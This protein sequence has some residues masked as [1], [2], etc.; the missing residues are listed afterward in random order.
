MKIM[1][2]A[3][4][5]AGPDKSSVEVPA[6]A[7]PI[8]IIIFARRSDVGIRRN[9]VLEKWVKEALDSARWEIRSALSSLG[10][11]GV[12]EEDLVSLMAEKSGVK[13]V[14]ELFAVLFGPRRW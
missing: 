3:V 14:V 11:Y 12:T 6:D 8:D 2:P 5:V 10:K 13:N 7:T 9:S 1:N 4:C